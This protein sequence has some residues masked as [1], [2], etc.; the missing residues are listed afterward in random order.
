[1]IEIPTPEALSKQDDADARE[2][3]SM[4]EMM[5]EFAAAMDKMMRGMRALARSRTPR[6]SVADMRRGPICQMKPGPEAANA[7]RAG[8]RAVR[9]QARRQVRDGIDFRYFGGRRAK[10]RLTNLVQDSV[11]HQLA[12]QVFA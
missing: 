4:E 7:V 11:Q 2:E 10:K 3:Q 8:N 6:R 9:R 12:E 5:S 1:M